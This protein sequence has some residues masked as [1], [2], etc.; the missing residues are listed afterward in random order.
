MILTILFLVVSLAAILVGA[1]MLVDGSSALARKFGM[2][3]VTVGLT[4]VAFGTSTP[5]LAITVVSALQGSTSLAVGN[6][7]GSNIFNILMIIGLTALLK[8]LKVE[9]SV[10]TQQMPVMVLAALV[11]LMLGNSMLLDGTPTEIIT[12][13]S[14]IFLLLLFV[15]FMIFTVF[16][17]KVDRPDRP[18]NNNLPA[19]T[20][21]PMHTE[22]EPTVAMPLWKQIVWI[23]VGLVGLVWGGDKFVDSAS[24]LAKALG[25]S[26]AMIGLTIV[27]MGTSLPELAASVVSAI[28]GNPGLAV[29]NVIGSNIFNVTMVLGAGAVC[30]PLSLGTVGNVDLLVLTAAS[31]CFWLM[32][33][34]WGHRVINRA[35]GAILLLA[36]V[37][38]TFWLINNNL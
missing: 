32:G 17:S 21:A 31:L 33:R 26:E 29:G 3:D 5:E 37:A 8:P 2:S 28:K 1:N 4:V 15:L 7:V 36:Y 24:E 18:D 12:R 14:G 35:E 6:V 20:H 25:M 11:M 22:E 9:K 13:T 38:Y 30:A 34:V 23:L 10:M 27:A 16:S 19:G